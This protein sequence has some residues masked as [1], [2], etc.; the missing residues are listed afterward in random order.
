MT[1]KEITDALWRR[2]EAGLAALMEQYGPLC[3]KIAG[4]ILPAADAEEVVADV[5]FRV[6]NT[7]PPHRPVSLAAYVC[8]ITRNLAINRY[9]H[10]KAARRRPEALTDWT[11]LTE[12]PD[13]FETVQA[14]DPTAESAEAAE[15]AAA[16]DR[17]LRT[18]P[19]E[20]RVLFVRRFVYL[21]DTD[22]LAKRLHLTKGHIHVK[23]HR[24]RKKLRQML[25]EEKLL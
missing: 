16:I 7:V 21:E 14:S 8:R 20:D 11:E 13:L 4:N 23:L 19:V 12:N 5:W 6:W 2:E 9:Y 10:N 24:L 22:A 17:F 25:E 3:R 15:T 18:L 1:S